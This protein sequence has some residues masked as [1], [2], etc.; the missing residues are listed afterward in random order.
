VAHLF[1]VVVHDTE[2]RASALQPG[3]RFTSNGVLR[4]RAQKRD[5]LAWNGQKY[6]YTSGLVM[7]GGRSTGSKIIKPPGFVYTYGFAEARVKI[8]SGRGFWP[9]FW[10]L[11]ASYAWPPEIDI[12]EIW[13]HEIATAAFHLHY[14]DS[15]THRAVGSAYTGPDFSAGLTPSPWTGS[16][17][18]LSGTWTESNAG[19]TRAPESRRKSMYLLLNLAVHGNVPPDGST[20]FPSYLDVD[21]VRVWQRG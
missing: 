14:N 7:T 10:T 20:P 13:S 19:A 2:Q 6:R 1:L 3:G 21:Y 4:L 15:G 9:A 12:F 18:R 5:L 8:P 16:R 17:R 11:P